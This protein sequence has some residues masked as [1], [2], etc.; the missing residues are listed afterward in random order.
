[1]QKIRLNRSYNEKQLSKFTLEE[2]RQYF[3][4]TYE[5]LQHFDRIN[6]PFLWTL[7]SA[8]FGPFFI[9]TIIS[10]IQAVNKRNSVSNLR[11]RFI[12]TRIFAP[13]V[14]SIWF[15]MC[16]IF[17]AYQL[18]RNS[19]LGIDFDISIVG[20]YISVVISSIIATSIVYAWRNLT[21]QGIR[22]I[23]Y[24]K[25]AKLKHLI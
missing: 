9:M 19:V 16:Q 5:D 10:S 22:K 8:L 3:S 23:Q 11:N 15:L 12:K 20:G 24:Y 13:T 4:A 7:L 2:R 14:L 6:K 1:M 18:F 21:L 17:G 25:L